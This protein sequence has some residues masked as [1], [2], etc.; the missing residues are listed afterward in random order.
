MSRTTTRATVITKSMRLRQ[1]VEVDGRRTALTNF[2]RWL[3]ENKA[4]AWCVFQNVTNPVLLFINKS[5]T[6]L[7]FVGGCHSISTGHRV[8]AVAELRL[9]HGTWNPLMLAD[10]AKEC[11]IELVGIKSF[12]EHYEAALER[13][14][15]EKKR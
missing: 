10:Y 6:V 8:L 4:T 3:D 9:D 15:Q 5:R 7:Q 14:R 13:K 12:K 2:Q 1:I 11:G